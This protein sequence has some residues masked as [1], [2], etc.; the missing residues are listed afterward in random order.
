[1]K[2]HRLPKV[3]LRSE[4]FKS[5]LRIVTAMM[6]RRSNDVLGKIESE[7]WGIEY[8]SSYGRELLL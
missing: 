2:T 6:F 7:S 1:M 8:L 5:L 4:H 3:S